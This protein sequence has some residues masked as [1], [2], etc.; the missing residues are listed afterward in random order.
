V[1]DQKHKRTKSGGYVISGSPEIS[2]IV[3]DFVPAKLPPGQTV[4]K[5]FHPGSSSMAREAV[6]LN[7]EPVT[8]KD[9]LKGMLTYIWPKVCLSVFLGEYRK[10]LN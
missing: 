9:M 4:R 5:C 3:S 10:I 2:N 7:A 6:P 8:S 1:L